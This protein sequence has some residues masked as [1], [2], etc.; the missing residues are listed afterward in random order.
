MLPADHDELD[1]AP[2]SAIVV[3]PGPGVPRPF[4]PHHVQWHVPGGYIVFTGKALEAVCTHGA[5]HRLNGSCRI[6]RTIEPTEANARRGGG[7]PAGFL[8][9][10]LPAAS[11]PDLQMF[12]VHHRCGHNKREAAIKFPLSVRIDSRDWLAFQPFGVEILSKERPLLT[13]EE[14][15][16]PVLMV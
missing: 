8:V 15:H 10:W 2:A 3:A 4:L 16:E 1:P 5:A 12:D 7:R 14:P 13:P 6:S 11:D 9:S